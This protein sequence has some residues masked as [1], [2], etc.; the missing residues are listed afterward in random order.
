MLQKLQS[1]N[2]TSLLAFHEVLTALLFLRYPL[3]SLHLGM[4][5]AKTRSTGPYF[6]CALYPKTTATLSCNGCFILSFILFLFIG[7]IH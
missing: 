4:P 3:L 6:K 7:G 1:K 5:C 2:L